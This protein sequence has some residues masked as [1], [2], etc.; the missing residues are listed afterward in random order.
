[1]YIEQFYENEKNRIFSNFTSFLKP[2]RRLGPEISSRDK[3]TF[4]LCD[5]RGSLFHVQ[6]LVA[7]IKDE[8]F[9]QC[10]QKGNVA[11]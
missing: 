5:E 7:H 1:M 9:S 4:F 11:L 6:N 10:S 8:I 2:H 3:A